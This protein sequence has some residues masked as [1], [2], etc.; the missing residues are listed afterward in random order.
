MPPDRVWFGEIAFFAGI[1]VIPDPS[2]IRKMLIG[3][4]RTEE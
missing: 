2:P 1:H 4:V 3:Y